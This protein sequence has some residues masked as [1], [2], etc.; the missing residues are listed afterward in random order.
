MKRAIKTTLKKIIVLFFHM[1]QRV[2]FDIL[3]RH[4]YS[5]IPDIR[6]LKA[7]EHWRKPFSMIGIAG[8]DIDEQMVFVDQTV[9]RALAASLS[10]L[11]VHQKACASNGEPGYGRVE[12]DFLYAF[13]RQY[14]PAKIMQ[15]GCG[16]ST[17]ICLAAAK[18]AKY[19][20]E[21]ICI[22]PYPTAFLKHAKASGDIR[23][24]EKP[25]ELLEYLVLDELGEGDFFFVDSTHTLGPGG[26]VSRIILEMLPRLAQ[27][28]YIHFHDIVFPYDYQGD[29]LDSAL[30]FWHETSLLHAFLAGNTNIKVLASLSMLHHAKQAELQNYLPNYQPRISRLGVTVHEGDFPSSIYLQVLKSSV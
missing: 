14:R 3:P 24:I 13:I 18:A 20:P 4:F 9:S 29:I 11:E 16:V 28:I 19:R 2:G 26:E 27:G 15:I 21:I 17:A 7:S 5:E 25:V 6:K 22:E 23:L 12:A 10:T 1:A 8:I 30:F